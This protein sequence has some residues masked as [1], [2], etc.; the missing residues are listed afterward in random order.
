MQYTQG[1]HMDHPAQVTKETGKQGP[2]GHI[3]YKAT[4][5][6]PEDIA[7]LSNT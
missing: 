6:R 5:S 4:L 1:T 2:T 7:T 3:P